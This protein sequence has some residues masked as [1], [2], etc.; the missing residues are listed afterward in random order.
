MLTN[1][2]NFEHRRF[3]HAA[4]IAA[5]ILR[6]DDTRWIRVSAACKAIGKNKSWMF[7]HISRNRIPTKKEDQWTL[8]R[9]VDCRKVLNECLYLDSTGRAFH[10]KPGMPPANGVKASTT[11]AIKFTPSERKAV[12]CAAHECNQTLSDFC[13]VAINEAIAELMD[14]KPLRVVGRKPPQ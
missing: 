7:Y 5:G 13:R 12:E 6:R 2:D 9:V 11:L 8:V 4:H 14:A 1:D 3:A 10:A